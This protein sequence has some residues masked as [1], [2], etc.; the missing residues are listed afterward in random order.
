MYSPGWEVVFYSED[1]FSPIFDFYT[2]AHSQEKKCLFELYL[3]R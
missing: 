2:G 1:L 3:H